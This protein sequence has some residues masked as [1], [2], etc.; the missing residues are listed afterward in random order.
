MLIFRY[1]DDVQPIAFLQAPASLEKHYPS[2]CGELR[3]LK[4][5]DELNYQTEYL[6]KCHIKLNR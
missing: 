4:P 6:S 3:R 5:D 2:E 1:G